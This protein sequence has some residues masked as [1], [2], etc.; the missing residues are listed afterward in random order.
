M[1]LGRIELL[2]QRQRERERKIRRWWDHNG[3]SAGGGGQ[4]YEKILSLNPCSYWTC[5]APVSGST[6]EDISG[7]MANGIL[8]GDIAKI[9]DDGARGLGCIQGDGTGSRYIRVNTT[10]WP[11]LTG[12]S[13]AEFTASCWFKSGGDT[14]ERIFNLFTNTPAPDNEYCTLECRSG[15]LGLF[16]LL[17]TG[18]TEQRQNIINIYDNKWHHVAYYNSN[19]ENRWGLYVDGQQFDYTRTI[20][21]FDHLIPVNNYPRNLQ[22]STGKI[23]HIAYFNRVLTPEEIAIM[24]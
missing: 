12:F 7:N 13:V 9:E 4:Y 2:Q 17:H 20:N 5:L 19:S 22:A 8:V 18:A 21:A 14:A 16:A 10:T 3:H 15:A 24:I 23:Q 11:D 1:A 6:L